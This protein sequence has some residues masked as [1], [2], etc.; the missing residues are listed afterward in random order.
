MTT[1]AKAISKKALE[2]SKPGVASKRDLVIWYSVESM[3][4]LLQG[5]LC[6]HWGTKMIRN[7]NKQ[8]LDKSDTGQARI[9]TRQ[10]E[11]KNL[12]TQIITQLE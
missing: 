9:K 8:E 6:L 4:C 2:E 3:F 5:M 11:W 1:P 12:L 7:K 10:K